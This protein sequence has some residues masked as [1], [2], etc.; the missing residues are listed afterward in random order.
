M[1][2]TVF[3]NC[4]I[5]VLQRSELHRASLFLPNFDVLASNF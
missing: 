2:V 1:Q 5:S 3:I 4:G